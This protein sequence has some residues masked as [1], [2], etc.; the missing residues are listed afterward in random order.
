MSHVKYHCHLCQYTTKNVKYLPR[1]YENAH[2]M[3]APD[4]PKPVREEPQQAKERLTHKDIPAIYMGH[5][6]GVTQF[7]SSGFGIVKTP[8]N[9]RI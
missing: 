7:S 9:K 6:K 1:H 8:L 2:C 5:K 3:E 4:D